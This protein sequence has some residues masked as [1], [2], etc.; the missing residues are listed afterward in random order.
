VFCILTSIDSVIPAYLPAIPQG[1]QA[2]FP[3]CFIPR[4]RLQLARTCL[5]G[6]RYTSA[7]T[8]PRQSLSKLLLRFYSKVYGLRINQPILLILKGSVTCYKYVLESSFASLINSKLSYRLHIL[9]P[10]AFQHLV[11]VGFFL[12]R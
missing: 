11:H 9:D 12:H 6:L 3:S 4:C 2:S 8:N 1:W 5:G 7:W 10:M